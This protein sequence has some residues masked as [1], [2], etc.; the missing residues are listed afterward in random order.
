MEIIVADV[1]SEYVPLGLGPGSDQRALFQCHRQGPRNRVVIRAVECH[2]MDLPVTKRNEIFRE[3]YIDVCIDICSTPKG[4]VR[5]GIPSIFNLKGVLEN[6][7]LKN[8]PS[9]ISIGS[10]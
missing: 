8:F 2:V 4:M 3:S 5:W 10:V 1:F 7:I 9:V 6:E